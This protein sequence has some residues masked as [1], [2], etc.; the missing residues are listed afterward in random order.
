MGQIHL[1]PGHVD[2]AGSMS[3]SSLDGVRM[4]VNLLDLTLE[5][6]FSISGLGEI[7]VG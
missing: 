1:V 2:H 6:L 4:V 5:K 7:R 3:L